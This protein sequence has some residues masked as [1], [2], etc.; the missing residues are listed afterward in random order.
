MRVM[1]IAALSLAAGGGGTPL[2]DVKTGAMEEELKSA[3]TG[4]KLRS[5]NRRRPRGTAVTSGPAS[6]PSSTRYAAE[7]PLPPV[8]DDEDE[9]GGVPPPELPPPLRF[10]LQYY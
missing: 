4:T 2:G 8:P 7:V 3:P 5:P 6:S 1:A 9:A 10:K